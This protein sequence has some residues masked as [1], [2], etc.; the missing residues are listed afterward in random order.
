MK[1]RVRII[2][3]FMMVAMFS[4]LLVGFDSTKNKIFDEAGLLTAQEEA[5][6]QQRC[7]DIAMKTNVDIT[8]VTTDET[9][10]L[11]SKQYAEQYYVNHGFGYDS[12]PGNGILLLIDM[13]NRYAWITTSGTV[14]TYITDE[15]SVD[16]TDSISS[17]LTKKDYYAACNKYL[18]KVAY[19]LP[20]G[21]TE[22]DKFLDHL[23]ICLLIATGAGV[24]VVAVMMY[25]AKA[26]MTVGSNTYV[27]EQ[28]FDV[29]EKSDVYIN[30]TVV[31]HKIQT[32]SG[33][34]G[35][36]GGGGGGFGGGGSR[37]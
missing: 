32:N 15:K 4:M 34:S 1:N 30:T 17:K 19:A 33:S 31:R 22:M 24:A 6:L 20:G 2:A 16:I 23:F 29:L 28:E 27:N 37:F 12:S 26:R 5:K 7:I 8:I 11:T 18:D 25:N 14:K 13:D 3:V 36:G 21:M 10:G 9:G 35:G